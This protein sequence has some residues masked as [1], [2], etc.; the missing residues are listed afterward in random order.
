MPKP[1]KPQGPRFPKPPARGGFQ[2][3]FDSLMG[4]R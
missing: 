1:T 4:K 2:D 3:W